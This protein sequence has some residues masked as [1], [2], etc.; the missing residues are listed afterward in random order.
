MSQGTADIEGV[1]D[2]DPQP[3]PEPLIAQTEPWRDWIPR[4]P[5][6]LVAVALMVG[7]GLHARLP[8]EPG[9]W[10]GLTSGFLILGWLIGQFVDAN[11]SSRSG[12]RKDHELAFVATKGS[13]GWLAMGFLLLGVT[14]AGTLLAQLTR[15]HY[16]TDHIAHYAAE[17]PRLAQLEIRLDTPPRLLTGSFGQY[18]ALPPKQVA[19]A[20]VTRVKCWDGWRDS[21]GQTLVQIAQPHPRLAQGQTLKVLGL[22]QRPAP[23]MN[24]GQFDWADYYRQQRILVSLQ[25][26]QTDNIEIVKTDDPGLLAR[27]RQRTR[28]LLASGIPTDR[29][30][31]H[32]LLRALVLGDPDPELRDVQDHF[33]RTGTS[34]H[35]AISGL[36]VAVLSAVILAFCRLIRLSP[37]VTAAIVL[38]FVIAYGTVALPSPPVIRSVLLCGTVGIGLLFGRRVDAVHLLFVAVILMLIVDPLDLYN[39]GFQLSFGTVLGLM[40]FADRAYK[41]WQQWRG[42]VRDPDFANRPRLVRWKRQLSRHFQLAFVAG[43][44]A[45]AVSAPLIAIHFGQLNPWAIPAGIVLAPIVF[46]ALIGGFLKVLLTLAFPS[47]AA[48]W[49]TLAVTPVGWM[50]HVVAWLAELP[51][52]EVPLPVPPLWLIF[53]YYAALLLLL[54]PWKRPKWQL[55]LRLA[56]AAVCL[57]VILLPAITQASPIK[58]ES[59]LRV[60]LLAVG[61][62]QTAVVQTP[63]DRVV[64]VDA[65]SMNLGDLVRKCLGPFLRHAGTREVNSILLTHGDYDHI[66]AVADVVGAYDVHE[67]FIGPRFRHHAAGNA[68]AE[69]MLRVLDQ[70]D[71]PPR[72]LSRGDSLPLGRD[73]SIDVLWPLKSSD[74]SSNDDAMVLRLNYAGKRILFTGDIQDDAI[75]ELLRDPKQL[76]A[77]VLIAP[78]HGSSERLTEAFLAAVNPQHVLS[79]NDRT[80]T[81]KQ[82]RLDRLMGSRP[83]YRT[84]EC[85]AITVTVEADGDLKVTTFLDPRGR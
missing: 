55:A 50:R 65:G 13:P 80:L 22:L 12:M 27:Y 38:G 35:L 53:A 63:G 52:S 6:I 29:S 49:G 21:T 20:T 67:T 37:R 85:G 46:I 26:L 1:V 79:S 59:P 64:L 14:S 11:A 81:G 76:A 39:A 25:I 61:A 7:I 24:P 51:G 15:Y 77:D 57:T 75:A 30:L 41:H 83:L 60:T 42:D 62:G 17:S 18:K 82:R 8:I 73:V 4:R 3:D 84:H 74:F 19:L 45:W 66:S 69:G 68:P 5:A 10:L 32:A 71:R 40:L 47:L 9:L 78:H 33:K 44:V 28:E 70:L 23:A 48:T 72:L 36:H 56:P 31:D 16:P 54:I 2:V 34:H 58:F 43:L